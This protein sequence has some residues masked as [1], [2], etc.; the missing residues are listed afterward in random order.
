LANPAHSQQAYQLT[1]KAWKALSQEQWSEVIELADRANQRWGARAREL[2][3]S[4]NAFPSDEQ[5]RGFTHLNEL[6]TITLIKAQALEK[7]GQE[8]A[9]VET[10]RMLVDDFTY[11]QCWD[12]QGWW[13]RPSEAARDAIQRLAPGTLEDLGIETVPLGPALKLAGKKGI[14]YTLRDPNSADTGNKWQG[15]WVENMPKIKELKPYWNYSW[16]MELRAVQPKEIEFMPM[17]WGAWDKDNLQKELETKVMPHIPSGRVKRFLGFNEPDHHDQANMSYE[18]ALKY[19]PQLEALGVPL[20]SPACAN[21]LGIEPKDSSTQG[22]QGTWM[23]DFMN[24]A[25]KRGYR[26]DY[27]GTHWYGGTS[28]ASFKR[29]MIKIYEKYGKR[30]LLVT[31]FSPAD[32]SAKSAAEHKHSEA[33]VLDFAKE[34]LPWMERQ[35]WIAGYAW[36][37]WNEDDAPGASAALFDLNGE[38]TPLGRF[39]RSVSNENPDGDQSITVD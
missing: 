15:T 20:V 21:T 4:L 17:A 31:E 26:V 8:A 36:F 13:W 5:A 27:I 22:I 9:A 34:V 37:C 25:D 29:T 33:A 28:A 32:W 6:A 11:G 23:R 1:A 38:L 39:Y 16:G 19:W 30:P 35:N 18:A 2:N 3:S 10:Y 24:E 7:S 12:N 14:G